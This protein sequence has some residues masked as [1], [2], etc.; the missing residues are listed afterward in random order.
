MRPQ[1]TITLPGNVEGDELTAE[2]W[3]G[4]MLFT[5]SDEQNNF[6]TVL[7]RRAEVLKL[8]TQIERYFDTLV[9]SDL[10]PGYWTTVWYDQQEAVRENDRK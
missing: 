6:S 7:L 9:K 4:N 2:V 1:K 10:L 3:D 8:K 5:C